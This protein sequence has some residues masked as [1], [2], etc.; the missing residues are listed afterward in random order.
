MLLTAAPP[1]PSTLTKA[2][3][4]AA[5]GL[6]GLCCA[7]GVVL[8]TSPVALLHDTLKFKNVQRFIAPTD[9]LVITTSGDYS[10]FQH[11]QKIIISHLHKKQ[12]YW[13]NKK[14]DV[15]K[16]AAQLAHMCYEKRN[17]QDPYF[18][19]AVVAGL[20]SEGKNQLYYVDKFGN[21]FENKFICT[22]F[23]LYI[24]PVIIDR[25][26]NEKM[27][28]KESKELLISC[29]KAIAARYTGSLDVVDF[30]F[31]GKEGVKFEREVVKLKYDYE[32]YTH[33]EDFMNVK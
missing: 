32:S 16:V 18:I 5:P 27:G 10:D 31:L 13:G 23:A 30:A 3:E 15:K 21:F 11:L 24:C 7:E 20:D 26:F 12:V 29:F 33:K 25:N 28:F 22:G 4:V 17:E 8:A 6:I 14:A 2:P 9:N 1:V 19:E